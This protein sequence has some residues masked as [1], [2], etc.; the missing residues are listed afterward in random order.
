MDSKTKAPK[1]N[2]F[3]T[4]WVAGRQKAYFQDDAGTPLLTKVF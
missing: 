1:M 2:L 3:D 4:Y